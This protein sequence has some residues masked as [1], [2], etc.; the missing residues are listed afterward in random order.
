MNVA[1]VHGRNSRLL[2]HAVAFSGYLKAFERST[3]VEMA[4][5]TVFGDEGHR[6][7][8]GLESGTLSLDGL[9]DTVTT[10]GSQDAT[11]DGALQ[12]SSTSVITAGVAG[13]A[14]G[15]RVYMIEA[16]ETNYAITAPVGDA[17]SFSSSD[18]Q[19]DHGLSLLDVTAITVTANGT[20]VDNGA[21]TTGGAA[22]T[23]HVTANTRDGTLVVKVQHSVDNSVWV[24]LIT[25]T[26]VGAGTTTA[27][28]V[29]VS[30][31]VNRYLRHTRTVAG[32]TGSI[33][34]QNSAAR[35]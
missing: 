2:L 1:F 17:V 27:E 35:R 16:R 28:R 10:A 12:A 30:G 20:S 5:S 14:L 23:L 9:L 8:P 3:E 22:A 24:D 21:L 13:L 18:G 19:V 11:L 26:T 25:F 4:D 6:F 15:A 7:I 29:A 33:T 31:T 32:T 34:I